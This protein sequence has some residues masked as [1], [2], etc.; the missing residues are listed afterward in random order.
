VRQ[1]LAT[2]PWVEQASIQT[3]IP[4]RKVRFNLTDKTAWS[5]E[6]VRSALKNKSFPDVT[7]LTAP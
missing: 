1:A 7:V 6:Q 4:T 3:D 2:L 5:E